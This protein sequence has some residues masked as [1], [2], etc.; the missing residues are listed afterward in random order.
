MEGKES[1]RVGNALSSPW[2]PRAVHALWILFTNVIKLS[3]SVDWFWSLSWLVVVV[4]DSDSE[5]TRGVVYRMYWFEILALERERKGGRRDWP[6]WFWIGER[7]GEIE[8]FDVRGGDRGNFLTVTTSFFFQFQFHLIDW[9]YPS[10]LEGIK[11]MIWFFFIF[12]L[13]GS[14]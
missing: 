5:S 9:M 14:W 8:Q 4:C 12:F 6:C 7:T 1:Q 10:C 2:S 13:S 3:M 11:H